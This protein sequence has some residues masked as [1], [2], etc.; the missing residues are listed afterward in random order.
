[1]ARFYRLQIGSVYLTS[2][3]TSAGLP[4]KLKIGG[5]EAL[6]VNYAGQTAPSA[7]GTPQTV[8]FLVGTKS[9]PL[10]VT[11]E[12]LPK[13]VFDSLVTV[14]NNALQNNSTITLVGTGDYGD[15][16]IACVPTLPTP[17]SS[18]GEFINGRLKQVVLNFTTTS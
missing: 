2:D 4:C 11:V 7:D 10:S 12:T 5:V 14:I 8:A 3:G 1:M 18:S 9:R 6:R 17:I 15:F 16:N 13:T